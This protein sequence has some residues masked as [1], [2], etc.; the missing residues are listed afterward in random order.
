[1][2]QIGLPDEIVN[3]DGGAIAHGHAIGATGAVY[4]RPA[5]FTLNARWRSVASSRCALGVA[6]VMRLRSNFFDPFMSSKGS[7]TR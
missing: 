1:M 2:K 3:V 6:K 7:P 4:S 5:C